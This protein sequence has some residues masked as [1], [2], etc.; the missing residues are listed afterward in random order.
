MPLVT[1]NSGGPRGST[2]GTRWLIALTLLALVAVV[3]HPLRE[4]EFTGYDDNVY[5]TDNPY[6]RSGFTLENV[7]L[8]FSENY[9]AIRAHARG[10]PHRATGWHWVPQIGD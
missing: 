3:F 7:V 10:E 9:T 1:Q 8:A 6:L 4:H 2:T 5:I